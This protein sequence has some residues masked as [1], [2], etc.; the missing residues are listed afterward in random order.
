MTQPPRVGILGGT[1][2]PVH[3][4]HLII[5]TELRQALAL[6]RV[7][8]TPAARNPLKATQPSDD[9]HRL[10]M[11]ELAL[12][13]NSAF[14]I[15]TVD[16]DRPG[17][18][19]TADLLALLAAELS[20]VSLVFLMGS[21]SLRDFPT[22]H[23]PDRIIA[24]A[25]LGVAR[26]PAAAADLNEIIAAVPFARDRIHFVDVPLIG[27]SATDIRRRVASGLPIS[28]QVPRAVEEYI[29]ER[30]LYAPRSRS[31]REWAPGDERQEGDRNRRHS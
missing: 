16:L 14:A 15:S 1:F 24:L 11:L 3:L 4:G 30:G 6:D 8:F 22:W 29:E 23:E 21:D 25:E 26:R 5:A 10:R 27:I 28:Y 18:S 9:R 17:P 12:A 13:D 19:F 7:L 2:D 31:A 20:P